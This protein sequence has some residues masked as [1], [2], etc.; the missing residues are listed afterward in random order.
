[1]KHLAK[2]LFILLISFNAYAGTVYFAT[3][4]GVITSA[5][6][7]FVQ[8]GLQKAINDNATAFVIKLDTPG[9]VL[10]DTRLI[11][12]E[13]LESPVPVVVFVAPQ[14]AHAGSA[15]AFITLAADY[16]VMSDGSNIGA[17]HPVDMT[18]ADIKGDMRD[19]AT[20]DAV[21]FMQSIAEKRGRNV[22]QAIL[23]VTE[24]DSLTATE[25]LEANII[26]HIL[27]TDDEL[28]S[29]LNDALKPATPLVKQEIA[30]TMLEKISFTLSDPNLMVLLFLLG[31]FMIFLEIKA[32]GTFV[33]AAIGIV[34]LLLFMIGANFIP[35]NM[36]G[37][38]LILC[39]IALLI[40]EIFITS[41]GLL[42]IAGIAAIAGGSRLLFDTVGSQGV[43]VSI[44]LLVLLSAM[45]AGL[46]MAVGR[47]VVRDFRR[48]PVGGMNDIVGEHATVMQ[49]SG[50]SGKVYLNGEIW[51][52]VSDTEYQKDEQVTVTSSE[53]MT[54]TVK[55]G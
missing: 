49:W 55:R 15:G 8:N 39:G 43:A 38:L 30:P 28:L 18:G 16:A 19:K 12:Q 20:N 5:T 40:A 50:T 24:S 32:P 42:S 13:I 14:G 36:L 53:N 37:V 2:I 52:A 21:S 4:D 23:M 35:I 54:L 41:F 17:A 29:M 51:S 45:T 7:K 27:N 44:W 25:A 48:K 3:V 31:I 47:L 26:D 11:V 1:M 46:I 6:H 10:E 9:G 33:F 22:E 34:S